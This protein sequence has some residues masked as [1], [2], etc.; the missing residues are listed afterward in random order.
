VGGRLA[1]M[2]RFKILQFDKIK[3]EPHPVDIGSAL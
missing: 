1:E 3:P 2:K